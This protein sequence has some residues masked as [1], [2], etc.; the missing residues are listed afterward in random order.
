MH[1]GLNFSIFFGVG[2]EPCPV[3]YDIKLCI[4]MPHFGLRLYSLRNILFI[5]V[6]IKNVL[7]KSPKCASN[8]MHLYSVVC[9]YL[10]WS[11]D[12]L[13]CFPE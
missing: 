5:L 2:G 7:M 11:E 3:N 12:L 4:S 10:I 9:C 6:I 13:Q 1:L 8:L